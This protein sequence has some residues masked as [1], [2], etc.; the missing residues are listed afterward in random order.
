MGAVEDGP[1]ANGSEVKG[2]HAP[3]PDVQNPDAQNP[4]AH[5]PEADDPGVGDPGVGDPEADDP[6]ADDPEVDGLDA[7]G[8]A[9]QGPEEPV[10]LTAWVR[11]QVQGVGFRWWVR[12][13]ALEL[14]LVGSAANLR[15]RRV[16]VVAE[17]SRAGC[18]R[19][20]ELLRSPGTPG[21]VSGV[22][23]QWDESRGGLV[24]FQER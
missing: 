11:G 6:E 1:E 10:R 17:G 5:G 18:E 7:P 12:A 16:E 9:A 15:D 8:S 24:G 19:L 14:G 3:G 23:E 21:R 2:P 20:L 13:R 4:N 22:V